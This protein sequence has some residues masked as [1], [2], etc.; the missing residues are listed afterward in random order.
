MARCRADHIFGIFITSAGRRRRLDIVV[1]QPEEMP[2]MLVGWI[3]SRQFLRFRHQLVHER[4]M[5]SCQGRC[6]RCAAAMIGP[7]CPPPLVASAFS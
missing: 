3:G 4:G 6:A 7:L 1:V 5:D 2:Y